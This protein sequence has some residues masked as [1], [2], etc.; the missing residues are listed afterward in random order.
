MQG[1]RADHG[2]I[3]NQC[4]QFRPMLDPPDEV[5]VARMV[6]INNRCTIAVGVRNQGVD[7]VAL[8]HLYTFITL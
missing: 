2:E 4:T 1:A 8:V 6:L 3:G 7:T 5:V